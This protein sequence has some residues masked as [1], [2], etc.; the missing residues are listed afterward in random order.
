M[1]SERK[2]QA[3]YNAVSDAVMDLRVRVMTAHREDR[4]PMT[5]DELDAVLYSLQCHAAQLA[6]A[7]YEGLPVHPKKEA[8]DADA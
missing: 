4:A 7:A 5:H 6:V 2:A 1:A 3:I 8:P